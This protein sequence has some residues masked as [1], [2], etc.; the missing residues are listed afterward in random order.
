MHIM[1]ERLLGGAVRPEDA[2]RREIGSKRGLEGRE[3]RLCGLKCWSECF[4]T[5]VGG[6]LEGIDGVFFNG[7]LS[8]VG[9]LISA[10]T[11]P[12]TAAYSLSQPPTASQ[13]TSRNPQPQPSHEAHPSE[14]VTTPARAHSVPPV[15]APAGLGSTTPSPGHSSMHGL[16]VT[17]STV[18]STR[19]PAPQIQVPIPGVRLADPGVVSTPPAPQQPPSI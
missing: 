18:A 1:R 3:N 11:V 9:G 16:P 13:P 12:G 15:A 2:E 8:V 10:S 4:R 7:L 6:D 5:I 19:P 14:Q 17:G